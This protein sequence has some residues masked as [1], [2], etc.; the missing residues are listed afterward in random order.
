M[1]Y[2]SKNKNPAF[3]ATEK[4]RIFKGKKTLLISVLTKVKP[5]L[6]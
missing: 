6:I 1:I 4:C 2:Y 3:R 5:D